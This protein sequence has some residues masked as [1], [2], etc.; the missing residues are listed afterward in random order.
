MALKGYY[1]C[2][3]LPYATAPNPLP[4][5][6]TVGIFG[7]GHGLSPAAP[8]AF[9]RRDKLK[10]PT[11]GKN[12]LAIPPAPSR[13]TPLRRRCFT[14]LTKSHARLNCFCSCHCG[15]CCW[16]PSPP[17]PPAP[18]TTPPLAALPGSRVTQKA[19]TQFQFQLQSQRRYR[20]P[21]YIPHEN[22]CLIQL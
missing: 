9:K 17:S 3:P 19:Q 5:L 2:A 12:P 1:Q 16:Y 4:L 13:R 11:S 15:C 14:S 6:P 7:H 20:F 18:M 10:F 21:D 8:V 22:P